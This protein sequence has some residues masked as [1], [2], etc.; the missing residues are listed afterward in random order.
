MLICVKGV[1]CLFPISGAPDNFRRGYHRQTCTRL[2]MGKFCS[3][4]RTCGAGRT[5][6]VCFCPISR[7]VGG[8][9]WAHF[10]G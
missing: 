6:R 8:N 2:T 1:G 7:A 10:I 3:E 5:L 9:G 4:H